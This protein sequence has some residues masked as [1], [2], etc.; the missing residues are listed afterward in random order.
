MKADKDSGSKELDLQ[1]NDALFLDDIDDV[2][3]RLQTLSI[4]F[5]TFK[6]WGL[7]IS[8]DLMKTI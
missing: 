1:L 3:V 4:K 5:G 7:P 2:E 6:C 8:N